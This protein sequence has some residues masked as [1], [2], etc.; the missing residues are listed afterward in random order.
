MALAAALFIFNIIK[1]FKDKKN[2]RPLLWLFIPICVLLGGAE[3]LFN[4]NTNHFK[5]K[6]GEVN[7]F[8][9]NFRGEN[10]GFRQLE[11]FISST[12]SSDP[13][14]S[15]K[16]VVPKNK[17]DLTV[18]LS[19]AR[20]RNFYLYDS[21]LNWFSTTWY[22]QRYLLYNDVFIA[23]DFDIALVLDYNQGWF[24]YFQNIGVRDLY[25]I[26]GAADFVYGANLDPDRQELSE[27]I[28]AAILKAKADGAPVELTEIKN[29]Q[30]QLS[31][32]V[33]KLKLN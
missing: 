11:K 22:F 27:K 9:S 10:N 2:L 31:F 23:G 30:K 16:I 20:D 33:Y 7:I 15:P 4:F 5:Q 6:I 25:F 21:S 3:L 29:N 32:K 1:F 18:S 17:Q 14:Y 24:N 13:N 8:Y 26:K 19:N 28:E 12:L